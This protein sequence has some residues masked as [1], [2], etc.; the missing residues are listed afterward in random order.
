[1]VLH[2]GR[3]AGPPGRVGPP[4][5][6][7]GACPGV[8]GTVMRDRDPVEVC[9]NTLVPMVIEQTAR[10][11]RAFDIYSRLL[12][13]RIIF[14]T[15]PVYDQVG[16]LLCA[17]L[18]FL[19]SENPN[20]DE[21]VAQYAV[22]VLEQAYRQIGGFTPNEKLT[23]PMWLARIHPD[24]RAMVDESL[25][26]AVDH[27]ESYDYEY[28]IYR[29]DGSL[30]WLEVHSQVTVDETGRATRLTG[31][32]ND[33]T[34]RKQAEEEIR[35]LNRDLKRRLDELQ[36][37]LDVAPIG[38]F[39]AHDPLCEVITSNP[40]G[41][42]MLG[43]TP[44]A[45]ASKNHP[46]SALPFRVMRQGQEVP[47]HEGDLALVGR[48]GPDDGLLHLAGG[49]LDDGEAG[50]GERRQRHASRLTQQE[51]RS[52][53]HVDEGLLN[54]GF[55]WPVIDDDG[56]QA[57][58][59]QR[60]ALGHAGARIGLNDPMG[61][62]GEPA[63]QHLDDAPAGVTKTGIDAEN[64]NRWLHVAHPCRTRTIGERIPLRSE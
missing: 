30:R 63:A 45:N 58:G 4:P 42:K 49:E 61:K 55:V 14:L 16:S 35:R 17:Q 21:I 15:G 25:R 8:K 26:R 7:P 40:A 37:L 38:I 3:V 20:K 5:A 34:A 28:R 9:N 48:S 23:R 13:E 29:P 36:T 41:A 39:V 18:L 54:C 24:D 12:K 44:T 10:G 33:V 51:G 31:A 19:E 1:M 27:G 2:N 46:D 32:L 22:P 43:I 52:R 56:A 57:G 6:S 62:P 59:K 60:Q 64:S 53:I 47:H 50:G 11:E